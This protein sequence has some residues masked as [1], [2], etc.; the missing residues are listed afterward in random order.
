VARRAAIPLLDLAEDGTDSG[1]TGSDGFLFDREL[2]LYAIASWLGSKRSYAK[3]ALEIVANHVRDSGDRAREEVLREAV[4]AANRYVFEAEERGAGCTVA[5]LSLRDERAVVAHVGD[6]YVFRFGGG[7][8]ERLTEAHS[9]LNDYIR[10]KKPSQKEVEAFP[11]EGVLVR[12][13]GM[14]VDVDVE[15]LALESAPPELWLLVSG[16]IVESA[17]DDGLREAIARPHSDLQACCSAIA[18]L[19]G[20]RA[21]TVVVVRSLA[22]GRPPSERGLVTAG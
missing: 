6:D 20:E 19:A 1:G 8:I 14:R 9:L 7:D 13:L 11:H 15:V 17:G 16:A 10:M 3:E 4:A 22:G 2:G 21:A 12:A 5:V 18:A